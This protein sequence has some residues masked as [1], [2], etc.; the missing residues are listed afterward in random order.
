MFA[1]ALDRIRPSFTAS[2]PATRGHNQ[3]A[4]C[5]SGS[6]RRP[7]R[8]RMNPA[9]M[10]KPSPSTSRRWHAAMPGHYPQR[11]PCA[12]PA[13]ALPEWGCGMNQLG[14]YQTVIVATVI[15]GEFFSRTAQ[16]KRMI[17]AAP[18]GNGK[19]MIAGACQR[20]RAPAPAS[21]SPIAAR[22]SHRPAASCVIS[23]SV[24]GS[25]RRA[26]R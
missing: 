1:S 18:I 9:S 12:S 8:G 10:S 3:A 7:Y 6:R 26:S 14:P 15:V 25:S 20:L 13:S 24:T 23:T 11:C 4:A 21:F 5:T 22:S 19:T 2:L 16:F 17:L